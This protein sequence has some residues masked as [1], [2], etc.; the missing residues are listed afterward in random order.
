MN[1]NHS[2]SRERVERFRGGLR[3]YFRNNPFEDRKVFYTLVAI[4][5]S[6]LMLGLWTVMRSDRPYSHG[7]VAEVHASFDAKCE[8]CHK[9]P[10][11]RGPSSLFDPQSR[12]LA[13]ECQSCHRGPVH[14]RDMIWPSDWPKQNTGDAL[15]N[16]AECAA[17]HHD[18]NGKNFSL[19]RLTDD[20]CLKCHGDLPKWHKA[21]TTDYAAKIENFWDKSGGHPEFRK[22]VNEQKNAGG[23]TARTLKFSHSH[24]MS[25]G[26]GYVGGSRLSLTKKDLLSLNQDDPKVVEQYFRKDDGLDAVVQLDC[27][28]CHQLDA[29]RG[30]PRDH[31]KPWA[32]LAGEPRESIQ[33]PRAQGAY[34]LPIN[35]EAHCQACHPL[36][37]LELTSDAGQ[38]FPEFYLPHRKQPAELKEVLRAR[39]SGYVLSEKGRPE[40]LNKNVTDEDVLKIGN[41]VEQ[42][43]S[44]SL[45]KLLPSTNPRA[46]NAL[47][48]GTCTE[49]HLLE[50]NSA[51]IE[52]SKIVLPNIPTVWFEH[53]KFDHVAHRAYDCLKCHPNTG[54]PKEFDFKSIYTGPDQKI[55]ILG[56]D[57]CRE[58][59]APSGRGLTKD[60]QKAE[61]GIRSNCTDCHRYHNGD[62]PLQGLGASSRDPK[63]KL[64]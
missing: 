29:E 13:L 3:R 42:A 1:P 23:Q 26:I 43:V 27:K 59:H 21:G 7:P 52:E 38:K 62:F 39:Y 53:S 17:C 8:A 6:L 5:A 25:P 49:C 36:K 31:S 32:N 16:D 55:N 46:A 12:W 20:H 64:K 41:Q 15:G 11:E 4:V 40:L 50:G 37:S 2:P 10:S 35:F 60:G 48:G 57:S 24:H 34:F 28:H 18:H 61:A 45:M 30:D 58:C 54:T 56:V 44:K 14:H 22:L 19:V 33:P 51:K 9:P 47:S 63:T